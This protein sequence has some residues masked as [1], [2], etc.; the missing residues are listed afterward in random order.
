MDLLQRAGNGW[1]GHG[2]VYCKWVEKVEE[3]VDCF[4][5]LRK[6]QERRLKIE[7]DWKI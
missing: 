5:V 7:D 6:Y 2:W 1:V 3:V 4:L